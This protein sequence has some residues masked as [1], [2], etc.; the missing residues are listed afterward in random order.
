[1][2]GQVGRGA[3][4]ADEGLDRPG[5]VPRLG[6]RIHPRPRVAHPGR[7]AQGR[8]GDARLRRQRDDDAVAG[9]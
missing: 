2:E 9:E 5:G 4:P 3:E 6:G 1:M 8:H 7:R